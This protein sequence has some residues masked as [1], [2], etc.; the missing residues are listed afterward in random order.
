MEIIKTLG[1]V[2]AKFF[3]RVLRELF[4]LLNKLKE[5]ATSTI[6]KNNP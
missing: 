6:F 2:P 3:D 4:I 5:I 1:Q